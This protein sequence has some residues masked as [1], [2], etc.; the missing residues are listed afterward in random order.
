ME[1]AHLGVLNFF[2]PV[3]SSTLQSF[4]IFLCIPGDNLGFSLGMVNGSQRQ[5]NKN[6]VKIF[7]LPAPC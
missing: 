5:W 3:Y 1:K 2:F 4:F 6:E 7:I